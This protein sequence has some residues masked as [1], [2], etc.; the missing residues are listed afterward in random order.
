MTRHKLG[1]LARYLLFCRRH[2]TASYITLGI[3][4]FLLTALSQL[5]LTSVTEWPIRLA[6]SA[7]ILGSIIAISM[8]PWTALTALPLASLNLISVWHLF[9]HDTSGFADLIDRAGALYFLL[10]TIEL[11]RFVIA[12]SEV[13]RARIAAAIAG[14]LISIWFFA[15]IYTQIARQ[16]PEAFRFAQDLSPPNLIPEM[17]YFSTV[18]Q[19]TLGYGDIV[20]L[21]G[22]A[23]A[24]V[25]SQSLF[26]VLYL[27]VAIAR[28]I[29]LA[30]NNQPTHTSNHDS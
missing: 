28:L 19:T 3:A 4:L 21:S 14:Y 10:I 16:N 22:S 1:A 18:T 11:F 29:G 20:P 13:S 9:S 30:S 15:G 2:R 24:F 17:V 7:V 26:G 25:L 5:N 6:L 8:R 23:R 12:G 27:A